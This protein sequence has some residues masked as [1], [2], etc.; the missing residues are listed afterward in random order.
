MLLLPAPSFRCL[1]P[2]HLP[3][4]VPTSSPLRPLSGDT[5]LFLSRSIAT[6]RTDGRMHWSVIHT[7]V[8]GRSPECVQVLLEAGANVDAEEVE[9]C[10]N[11]R[12]FNRHTVQT[13]LHIA[14]EMTTKQSN[15]Q[16][17]QLVD[18]LLRGGA[19]PNAIRQRTEQVEKKNYKVCSRADCLWKAA[20]ACVECTGARVVWVR[21]GTV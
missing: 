17:L 10:H 12:G 1:Q 11:E 9:K 13:A 4:S 8:R 7:A 5:L 15:E 19:D 2:P 20:D 16:S 6:M 3:R 18:V 14:C 21:G